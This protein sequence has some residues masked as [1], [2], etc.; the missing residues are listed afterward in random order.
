MPAV[1]LLDEILPRYDVAKVHELPV[2]ASAERT[3]EAMLAADLRDSAVSRALM[4]LRGYG[5]R[6]RREVSGRTLPQRL[7]SLGFVPLGE[8]A[9][10]EIVLGLVG[11]FWTAGGG[12]QRIEPGDFPAF[13]QDGFGKVAWNLAIEPRSESSCLLTTETRVLCFGAP[14]RRRFRV[15]WGL[16]EP[17]SGIIRMAMLRSIR[18]RALSKGAHS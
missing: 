18:R 14:A 10:S 16:I 1:T 7:E 4:F 11:K 9:G 5:A 6:A 17:F 13:R 8:R 12:L 3:W 2:P 15:Y